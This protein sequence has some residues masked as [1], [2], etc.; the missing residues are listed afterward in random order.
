[1]AHPPSHLSHKSTLAI[2]LRESALHGAVQTARQAHDRSFERWPPHINLLYPFLAAP[3]TQ[4]ET[5]VPRLAAAVARS[6]VIR[7][8]FSNLGHFQHS[9]KRATVFLAPDPSTRTEIQALQA[10]LQAAFPEVNHDTRPFEPHL[11]LGQA[12]GG[13]AGTATLRRKLE[14]AVLPAAAE[15]WTIASVVVLERNGQD[16]PFRVVHECALAD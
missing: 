9:P 7:G 1:M 12:G 8:Q 11:T 15:G 2:M 13:A 6:P 4:L 5:I 3:S 14:T 10:C 16:D